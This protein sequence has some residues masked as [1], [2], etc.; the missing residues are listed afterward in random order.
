MGFLLV[1]VPLLAA[2]VHAALSVEQLVVQGQQALFT[3]VNATRASQ[4]L[5]DAITNMERN[6]RQYQVLGDPALLDVYRENH[7]KFMETAE[8]LGD[9]KLSALQRQRL[10]SIFLVE[11]G[12]HS[13]ITEFPH[14]APQ[15]MKGLGK[16]TVRGS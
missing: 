12:I 2:L 14:D 15:V 3:T 16:F 13:I 8:R 5:V 6:A 7:Q 11:G 10:E 4:L 9:L 1:V